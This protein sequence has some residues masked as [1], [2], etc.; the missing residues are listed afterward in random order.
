M[1]NIESESQLFGDIRH[2]IDE[3]QGRVASAV[4]AELTWLY[5]QVGRRIQTDILQNKRGEYGKQIILG[6]S[7]QLTSVY[8]RGWSQKQLHHCLRFAESIA[9]EE[10]VSALRRQLNWTHIKTLIYIEDPLK[11][12]FYMEMCRLEQWSTRQLSER[13]ESQLY[14]R[15]ALSRKPEE[16]VRNDIE[17]LRQDKQLSSSLLL[18]DPYLLD[19]LDL[20]DHYIERDLEDAILRELESF[21][22]E[23]GRGFT[24]IARQYRIQLDG[25]DFYIDL[26]LYN[27]KLKRLV[28]IELKTGRFKAEYKGQMEFY[29]RWLSKYEQE[30]DE[31]SPLGI[32]LCAD[33]NQE[34]IELLELVQSGIHVAEYITVL[35]PRDVLQ[36]KLQQS[37]QQA[38]LRMEQG[39]REQ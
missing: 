23:L 9:D 38:R 32:I 10:I 1:R 17:K 29:L 18:K 20:S 5:W 2:L 7:R 8:G 12:D 16:T 26:L 4:N 21:L 15:T 3:A 31:A 27:R 24:F 35:P 6:L 11:R 30:H 37:I 22:L 14:E 13:I 34:Q 39:E 28:A 33:K 19:F 25:E 36:A